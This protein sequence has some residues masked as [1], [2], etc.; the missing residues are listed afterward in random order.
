MKA[1]K[2][3]CIALVSGL[4]IGALVGRHIGRTTGGGQAILWEM[5]AAAGYE[6]LTLL[7]Y[8]QAD[9]DH[10][11][12]ALLGFTNFSKSMSRL[13]SAQGDKALLVDTGRAYLRLAAIEELAGNGSLSHQYVL[14]AQHTFKSMGRDISEDDL[15]NQVAKI[16]ALAR[17]NGPPS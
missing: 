16:A 15:N 13:H 5:S 12:Q 17:P 11:R 10:S 14:D 4:V 2:F 9:T 1:L 3:C 7:Q 6:Q 8:E